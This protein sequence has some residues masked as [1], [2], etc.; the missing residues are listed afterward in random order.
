MANLNELGTQTLND[1]VDMANLGDSFGTSAPPP[2]PGPYRLAL[3]PLGPDNFDKVSSS[4][5]GDRVKVKFDDAAPLVIVQSVGG[6][7]DGEPFKTTLTNTPRK[8]GKKD[9]PNAPVSSDW[10]LLNRALGEE[11]RPASNK[12]YAERLIARSQARQQFGADV[13][14]S[15]Q[16]R[17]DKDIFADNGSGG[18]A[19]VAGTKGC[20]RRYYQKDVE[21]VN[22]EFP[23]RI[24]CACG[25]N[26]RAFGNL[27][28]FRA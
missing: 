10:D 5:Y 3:S 2:Q 23:L 20:G 15:W 18:F 27:T 19:Q 12:A 4:E 14:W 7:H 25:A 13:E 11:T 21:K 24:T 17:D 1:G 8:R 16:C 26:I 22:G 6:T 28:K 9:D